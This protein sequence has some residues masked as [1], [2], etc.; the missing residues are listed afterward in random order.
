MAKELSLGIHFCAFSFGSFSNFS[1]IQSQAHHRSV[2]H[3]VAKR[4]CFNDVYDFD[5]LLMVSLLVPGIC[6]HKIH[7]VRNSSVAFESPSKGI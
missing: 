6:T 3:P 4:K 1:N 2:E 7:A 5:R